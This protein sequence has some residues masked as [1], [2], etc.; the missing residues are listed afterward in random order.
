MLRFS[1]DYAFVWGLVDQY[2]PGLNRIPISIAG[3]SRVLRSATIDNGF[4]FNERSVLDWL[5]LSVIEVMVTCMLFE[6]FL[7]VYLLF[8]KF[9]VPCTY[10]FGYF[11]VPGIGTRTPI[12]L[13]LAM[14]PLA[15]PLGSPP[16]LLY[17][18]LTVFYSTYSYV[19]SVTKNKLLPWEHNIIASQLSRCGRVDSYIVSPRSVCTLVMWFLLWVVVKDL[20]SIV[21]F[22]HLL[23]CTL[24]SLSLIIVR[25][26]QHAVTALR[27]SSAFHFS[28]VIVKCMA[29]GRPMRL[30]L[31]F[32]VRVL[33]ASFFFVHACFF[34]VVVHTLS[35]EYL[36][37]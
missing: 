30:V 4:V 21:P 35:V 13:K 5:R 16:L 26:R 7:L 29:K 15:M 33:H 1:E 34:L 24:L 32:I 28:H 3:G 36:V 10:V 25:K 2:I 12:A 31:Y 6:R 22:Y 27:D 18:S 14:T 9:E 11:G 8:G 37:C 17:R 23:C 20:I 19:D